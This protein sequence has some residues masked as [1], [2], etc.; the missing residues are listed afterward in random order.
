MD[1]PTGAMRKGGGRRSRYIVAA[2]DRNVTPQSF[3][4]E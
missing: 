4:G 2:Q 3:G 1:S